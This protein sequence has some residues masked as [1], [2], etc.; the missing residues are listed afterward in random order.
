MQS[1]ANPVCIHRVSS[2]IFMLGRGKIDYVKH[3]VSRGGEEYASTGNVS[4]LGP[5]Q[6]FLVASE[7]QKAF[8]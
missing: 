2:R 6:L 8:S 4:H 5:F 3:T 1:F 7:P